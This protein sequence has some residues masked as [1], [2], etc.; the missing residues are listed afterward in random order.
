MPNLSLH[1]PDR[2]RPHPQQGFTLVELLV[3][4]L[5]GL[6]TVLVVAQVMLMTESRKRTTTSGSEATVNSA[7]AL[8]T[9]ERDARNAGYG[10]TAILSALGCEI[11]AVHKDTGA[12]T[13]T[14]T[15]VVIE[16]GTSDGPDKITFMTSTKDGAPLPVIVKDHPTPSANFKVN[17]SSGISDGDIMIAV[18][19]EGSTD[20]C[21]LFEV[22]K[23][24]SEKKNDP[25]NVQHNSGNPAVWNLPNSKDLFPPAGYNKGYL[26]NLGRWS[27]RTYAIVD[28]GLSLT[29]LNTTT[30]KADDARV[31]FP[32]IIQLQ[33]EYGL[34]KTVDDGKTNITEWTEATPGTAADWRMVKAIR[35]AV[36]AR[37]DVYEKDGGVDNKGVVTEEGN[38]A[39][40]D[41]QSCREASTRAVC[42]AG[43][44]IKAKTSATDTEWQHHRHRVYEAVIPIRNVIWR[45]TQ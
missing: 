40:I 43:G 41:Y 21:S 32:Q 1:R 3:A 36:V 30:G 9:I 38:L 15:P 14:L 31:L 24:G 33:A 23:D 34:D 13:F 16:Q 37:S 7:M 18:P 22:T 26:I 5:L 11:R 19:P 20:W 39:A 29:S 25:G 44:T 27:V 2:T 6:I 4:M 17:S 12:M 10:M 8:Y 28:N 42:W 35:V 45:E